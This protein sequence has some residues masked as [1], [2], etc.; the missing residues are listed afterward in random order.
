MD[1]GLL[2]ISREE[3]MKLFTRIELAAKLTIELHALYSDIFNALVG[4]GDRDHERLN[5]LVSL[6]NTRVE[7][8]SRTPCH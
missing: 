7:L 6:E 2:K 8:G 5:A 4:C 1:P 3:N